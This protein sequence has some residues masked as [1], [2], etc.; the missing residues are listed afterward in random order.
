M[1]NRNTYSMP[2]PWGGIIL[3]EENGELARIWPTIDSIQEPSPAPQ[4]IADV[5]QQLEA[6]LSVPQATPEELRET[7]FGTKAFRKLPEFTRR[8]LDIVSRIE[9]GQW[10]SYSQV[11]QTAGNPAAARAVGQ[12]LA[13]NPFPILIGCHRVCAS[14]QLEGF[15]ILKP[16]TFRPQAYLGAPELAAVAQWLRLADFSL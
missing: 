14:A 16:E 2:A 8:V 15:D 1:D 3:W 4:A 5:M 7:L 9:P 11:A 12:A 6:V 13:H 10:M